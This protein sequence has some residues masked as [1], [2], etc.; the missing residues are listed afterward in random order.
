MYCIANI[1]NSYQ[2]PAGLILAVRKIEGGR[3]GQAVKDPND[4]Y[5][6]GPMQINSVTWLPVLARLHISRADVLRN[7]CTN[8]AV[9]AWILR[10]EY[11]RYGN[12]FQAVAA[13]HAGPS[14]AATSIGINY[15]RRVFSVWG[16]QPLHSSTSQPVEYTNHEAP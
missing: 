16:Q 7:R 9:G 2:I 6:L 5:D 1:A 3:V 15:A 4:S 8:I 13:Y 14:R 12:W 10:R 11:G